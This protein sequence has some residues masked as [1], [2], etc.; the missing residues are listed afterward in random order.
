M[1]FKPALIVIL[2]VWTSALSVT[3]QEQEEP[4]TIIKERLEVTEVLLDVVVT[5]GAVMAV[6]DPVAAPPTASI[7][8]TRSIPV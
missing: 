3:A 5:D 2:A 7:G 4:E 1:R 6:D 8:S